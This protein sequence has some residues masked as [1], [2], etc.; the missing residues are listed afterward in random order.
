MNVNSK[1]SVN[2]LLLFCLFLVKIEKDNF[3]INQEGIRMYFLY[4][5]KPALSN[6]LYQSSL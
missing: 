1:F 2:F 3:E 4:N 6:V 5:T